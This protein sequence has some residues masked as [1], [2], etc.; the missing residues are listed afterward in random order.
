MKVLF[1]FYLVLLFTGPA[2]SKHLEI[3][4]ASSSHGFPPFSIYEN[5]KF[6][7][8]IPEILNLSLSQDKTTFKTISLPEKRLRKSISLDSIDGVLTSVD[9][10][11]QPKNYIFSEPILTVK[12]VL[13]QHTSNDK[14]IKSLANLKGKT[15]GVVHG[16]TYSSEI[17]SLFNSGEIKKYEGTDETHLLRLIEK[18][19]LDYALVTERVGWWIAKQKGWSKQLKVSS[20]ATG[21]FE[22]RILFHKKHKELIPELNKSLKTKHKE[23]AQIIAKYR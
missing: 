18:K 4:V 3:V 13:F 8:I 9:W 19:R 17:E 10:I 2:Y 6:G 23:I 22:Y 11:S 21:E 1:F 16:Y 15:I 7:G 5:G 12:D 14:N 20:L